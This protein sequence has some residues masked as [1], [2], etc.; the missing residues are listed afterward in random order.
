M[1]IMQ[2]LLAFVASLDSGNFLDFLFICKTF[3]EFLEMFLLEGYSF[4]VT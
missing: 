3:L 1:R 2:C 4:C